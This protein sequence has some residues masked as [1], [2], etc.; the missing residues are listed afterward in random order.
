MIAAATALLPRR[1][2]HRGL[3][4]DGGRAVLAA[5][6]GPLVLAALPLGPVVRTALGAAAFLALSA[7]VGLVTREDVARLLEGLRARRG[8]ARAGAP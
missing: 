8:A 3:L 6:G 5:F 4:R 1:A 2:L 7:A